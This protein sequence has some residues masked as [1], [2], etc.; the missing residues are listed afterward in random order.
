MGEAVGRGEGKGKGVWGSI[1]VLGRDNRRG[2]GGQRR[3]GMLGRWIRDSS[4]R[5]R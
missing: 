5:V 1:W 3:A 4:G 2:G